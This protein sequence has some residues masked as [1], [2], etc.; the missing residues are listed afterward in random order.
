MKRINS[1]SRGLGGLGC[2]ESCERSG[3]CRNSSAVPSEDTVSS[4]NETE[5]DCSRDEL[6]DKQSIMIDIADPTAKFSTNNML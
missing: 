2:R 1:P 6:R 4:G 5:R 3:P